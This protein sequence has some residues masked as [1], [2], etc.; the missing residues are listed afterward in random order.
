MRNERGNILFLILLAVVLFA[1][2]SYAVTSSMRGGG[3]D[4]GNEST[5]AGAATI[6]QWF[7]AIDAAVLRLNLVQDIKYEDI[8][9]GY[10]AQNYGATA[11]W[12]N[13]N[14]NTRCTTNTCRIFHTDGGG[15]PPSDFR[16]WAVATPTGATS[17]NLGPGYA[18]LYSLP[19]PGAGTELNDITIVLFFISPAVCKIINDTMGITVVPAPA[20]VGTSTGAGNVANWDNATGTINNPAPLIGKDT[21]ASALGGSG[22]GAYCHIRHLVMAR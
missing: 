14:H 8:S 10:T 7:A 21:F 22:D 2:L 1:A 19:W 18:V 15:V 16:K 20:V 17:A 11:T 12:S 5:Q 9:F 6:M 4:A 13:Y 3:R